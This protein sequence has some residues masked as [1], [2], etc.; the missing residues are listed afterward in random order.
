MG[1]RIAVHFGLGKAFDDLGDYAEA[2]HHY[3][4]ANRLRA[5]SARLDRT[6]LAAQYGA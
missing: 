4:K 2:M 1:S 6:A 5:K 3:D